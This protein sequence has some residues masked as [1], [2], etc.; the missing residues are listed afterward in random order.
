MEVF[1]IEHFVF[2]MGIVAITEA[3][4]TG[5][6]F[7]IPTY[8][9]ERLCFE[10]KRANIIFSA[11]S[12]IRSFTPFIAL[13]IFKLMSEKDIL[14]IRRVFVIATGGFA[15]L[16][17]IQN[18]WINVACLL[19]A[20]MSMGCASSLLWSIYIPGLGK[21][22]RV[23]SINGILDCFGYCATA[24]T[25]IVFANTID[26]LSWNGVI[27]IWVAIALV[28]VIFSCCTRQN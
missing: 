13:F 16:I 23:S 18:P 25:N 15:A 28:G 1:K 22:G 6:T 20:L 7:W 5:I 19:L 21:T 12:F 11:F 26:R 4:A 3:A 10:I 9:T 8:L 27:L 24:I 17:F 2:Y 14:M